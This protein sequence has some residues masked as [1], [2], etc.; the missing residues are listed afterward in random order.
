MINIQ[1]EAEELFTYTQKLRRDFHRNP[2]IGFQEF[3]TAGI[4]AYELEH[5]RLDVTKGIAKTGVMALLKGGNPGPILLLRFDMDALPVQEENAVDYASSK[6]GVMHACGHDAHTAI[7]LS[8]AKLLHKYRS[9]L[10][11][12]VKFMFQPAEEG[13]GGA[14][15]MIKDGILEEPKPDIALAMHVWNDKPI[16]WIGLAPGPVMAASESFLVCIR[17]KGGHGAMPSATIDPIMAAAQIITGL[18]SIVSRNVSP[19]NT[20]VVSVTAIHAGDAFNVIPSSVEI[21]GTIRTFDVDVR[22]KVLERFREIVEQTAAAMECQVEIN[23]RSIT[24]A[25]VNDSVI[26]K[27]VFETA[28]ELLPDFKLDTTTQTMGSE[29]MAF[30]LREIPGCFIFVG[31]A[32]EE[33]GLAYPHHHPRFD[34]DERVLPIAVSL[35]T[36]AAMRIL[37]G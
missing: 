34:I 27:Q 24:P 4:V 33:S 21:K 32:N 1:Q 8:V 13:L 2:E 3:R 29:D 6:N 11:G 28:S 36:A 16:G 30:V 35:M 23:I 15:A 20:A 5:L 7:G 18:Q 22:Q 9:E 25:L 37:A 10:H 12:S 26:T 19:L 14:E 31:S 17:G